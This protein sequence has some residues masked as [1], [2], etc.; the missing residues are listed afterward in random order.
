MSSSIHLHHS[1]THVRV[2]VLLMEG[3]H[4]EGQKDVIVI[5]ALLKYRGELAIALNLPEPARHGRRRLQAERGRATL[6]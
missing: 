2:L 4:S 3:Q 1:G 6:E 5:A